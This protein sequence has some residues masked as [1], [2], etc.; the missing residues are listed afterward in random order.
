MP[1][2]LKSPLWIVRHVSSHAKI[3]QSVT[4]SGGSPETLVTAKGV[5]IGMGC[6]AGDTSMVVQNAP[7]SRKAK[8][9]D[10]GVPHHHRRN[11]EGIFCEKPVKKRMKK[12]IAHARS[13]RMAITVAS[14]ARALLK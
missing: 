5:L 14:A 13:S 6:F 7:N 12:E 8:K 9:N 3:V 1:C 11:A 2:P 4:P 10:R